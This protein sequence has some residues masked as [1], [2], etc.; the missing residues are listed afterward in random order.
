MV[1]SQLAGQVERLFAPG[2]AT[3]HHLGTCYDRATCARVSRCGESDYPPLSADWAT[4][5]RAAT[6]RL[7][8]SMNH[9]LVVVP[10][11]LRRPRR[12]AVRLA[13][14]IAGSES[15]SWKSRS[16]A[17]TTEIRPRP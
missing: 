1:G 14:A 7:H 13:A 4:V 9:R 17:P 2:R 8:G 16:R 10:R 15:H 5:S 11:Q 6:D 3:V 12:P